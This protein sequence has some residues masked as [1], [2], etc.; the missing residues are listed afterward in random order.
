[1]EPVAEVV[2]AACC[3]ARLC[4][5]IGGQAICFEGDAL[6]V[7]NAMNSAEQNLSRFG[8]LVGL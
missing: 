2:M 5:D 4:Q 6:Q 8:H 3:A 1:M 7:V